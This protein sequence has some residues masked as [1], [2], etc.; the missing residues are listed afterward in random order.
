V[1]TGDVKPNPTIP[2]DESDNEA[3]AVAPTRPA[4]MPRGEDD[5]VTRERSPE[6]HDQKAPA[7]AQDDRKKHPHS[8]E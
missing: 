8:Y 1:K 2:V 7:S 3:P 5:P 4:S 6:F